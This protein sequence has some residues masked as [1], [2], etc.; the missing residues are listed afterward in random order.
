MVFCIRWTRVA[1]LVPRPAR[2]SPP[3]A[4]DGSVRSRLQWSR[5]TPRRCGLWPCRYSNPG[6]RGRLWPNAP[7][8]SVGGTGCQP[9]PS[10]QRSALGGPARGWKKTLVL[11]VQRGEG[12]TPSS[13]TVICTPCGH[14]PGLSHVLR[15]A[16]CQPG[17]A[18]RVR[19]SSA[20]VLRILST[21]GVCF[22]RRDIDRK[23]RVSARWFG[24]RVA[25]TSDRAAALPVRLGVGW[26]ILTHSS[27][28]R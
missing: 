19:R 7:G 20:R 21:V 23:F 15:L 5:E 6:G 8:S 17:A 18:C 2:A 13:V 12:S 1:R 9:V 24:L 22:V 3:S 27:C 16:P 26:G 10:S 4:A 28:V 25:A 14:L 11:K